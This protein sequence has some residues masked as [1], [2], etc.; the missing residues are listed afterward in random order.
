MFLCRGGAA[1]AATAVANR[2]ASKSE[3][4]KHPVI[5]VPV[6]GCSSTEQQPHILSHTRESTRVYWGFRGAV[7]LGVHK[8]ACPGGKMPNC[9]PA[10]RLP[11]VQR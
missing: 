11:C 1:A 8:K 2:C 4:S 9:R 5:Q 7:R 3:R 10:Q 6:V